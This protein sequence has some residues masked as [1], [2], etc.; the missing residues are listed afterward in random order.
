MVRPLINAV[1]KPRE[2]WLYRREL[3]QDFTSYRKQKNAPRIL[4][5][6]AKDFYDSKNLLSLKPSQYTLLD[7]P[8]YREAYDKFL[9]EA[10]NPAL[11]FIEANLMYDSTILNWEPFD[12]VWC[13]GVLYHNPEQLRM[14]RRLYDLLK[15]GGTLVI[16]SATTRNPKLM[17]ESCVEVIFPITPEMKKKLHISANVSHLP[18]RKAMKT[19]L[20]MVGFDQVQESFCFRTTSTKLAKTRAAFLATKPIEPKAGKYYT[21]LKEVGGYEIGKSC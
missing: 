2:E 11:Q 3:F 21:F 9:A 5:I 13:T 19:W 18:S 6:G 1:R 14:I 15:P 7:L 4:E 17:Q 12:V 20:E 16:E 8:G 10:K